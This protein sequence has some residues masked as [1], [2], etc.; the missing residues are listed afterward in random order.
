[1]KKLAIL[2]LLA[3]SVATTAQAQNGPVNYDPISVG[4]RTKGADTVY[5]LLTQAYAKTLYT[6]L[7]LSAGNIQTITRSRDTVSGKYLTVLTASRKD[8]VNLYRTKYTAGQVLNILCTNSA[9]D[10]TVIIPTAGTINGAATYWFNGAY[11]AASLYYDGT[12]Y[13]ILNKQ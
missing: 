11:K 6:P 12:N 10:S 4:L 2:I 13:F 3:A 5:S 9:N 8:T 1:M 7:A